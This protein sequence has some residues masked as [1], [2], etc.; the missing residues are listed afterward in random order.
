M[1]PVETPVMTVQLVSAD[2]V[3]TLLGQADALQRKDLMAL[4]LLILPNTFQFVN[5]IEEHVP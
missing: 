2:R 1:H 5:V 3:D 4:E